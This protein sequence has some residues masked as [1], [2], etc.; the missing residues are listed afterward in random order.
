MI[1]IV[2]L[3]SSNA[4]ISKRMMKKFNLDD[5]DD[6]CFLVKGSLLREQRESNEW[7]LFI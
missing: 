4:F 2:A 7:Q 1:T 3:S 5:D 6:N